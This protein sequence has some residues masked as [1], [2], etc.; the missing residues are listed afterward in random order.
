ME[1]IREMLRGAL[2]FRRRFTPRR[3]GEGAALASSAR[4]TRRC[5][6]P[7]VYSRWL[8]AVR[9][10]FCWQFCMKRNVLLFSMHFGAECN[11]AGH[12]EVFYRRGRWG[13]GGGLIVAHGAGWDGGW[14]VG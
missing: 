6:W 12:I 1:L 14:E 5:H 9:R 7:A 8:R 4:A 13:G 10:V 11:F 2:A 3:L